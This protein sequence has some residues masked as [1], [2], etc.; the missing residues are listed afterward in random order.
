MAGIFWKLASFSM[1]F[2][3]LASLSKVDMECRAS[4]HFSVLTRL[5]RE[6]SDELLVSGFIEATLCMS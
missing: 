1:T 6:A 2:A 3:I 5:R 4:S